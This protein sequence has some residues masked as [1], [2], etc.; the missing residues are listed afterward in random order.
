MIL[1]QEARQSERVPGMLPITVRG[2]LTPD[3]WIE[4][5]RDGGAI[6]LDVSDHGVRL[7]T[8]AV[9]ELGQVV[10]I[11]VPGDDVTGGD[12][13]VDAKVVWAKRND[14]VRFGRW[15]CGLEFSPAIQ[16]GIPHLRSV[17]WARN[18]RPDHPEPAAA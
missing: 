18:R 5:I 17:H 4:H 1:F 14:V 11:S 12:F 9:H 2:R 8:D 16:P 6:I 10:R 15:S 13:T 7:S 3:G